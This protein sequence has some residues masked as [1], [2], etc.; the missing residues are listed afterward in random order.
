MGPIIVHHH[1][2]RLA[3]ELAVDV[4]QEP[5]KL[6]MAVA[7]IT[8]ANDLT[9]QDID[10]RK[11]SRRPVAIVIVGHCAATPFLEWQARLRALQSL[12]LGL[13]VYAQHNRLVRRIQLQTD[14]VGQF[15]EESG[16]T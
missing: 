16:V 1:M 12:N 7:L 5:Q 3:G 4:S 13:L 10:R 8:V 15:L 9:G 2:Q 6:L 14:D 11:Q